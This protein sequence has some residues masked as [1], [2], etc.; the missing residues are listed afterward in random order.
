MVYGINQ[1]S[2]L[3]DE[4]FA[5]SYLG[6][7]GFSLNG[8]NQLKASKFSS[9]PRNANSIHLNSGLVDW[10]GILTTP[11]KDQGLCGSCW[12]FAAIGTKMTMYDSNICF[13][14]LIAL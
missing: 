4:E 11:V 5:T 10:T 7:K 1:F 12:A 8:T 3:T 14:Y 6:A 9:T 13:M 2:D